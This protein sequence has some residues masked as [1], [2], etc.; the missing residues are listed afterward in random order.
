MSSVMA[1]LLFMTTFNLNNRDKHK[2]LALARQSIE[3]GL[4]SGKP[5]SINVKDYQPPLTDNAACFVTLTINTLNHNRQLRGCIGSLEARRPLVRDIC[6]NAFASAFCDSRFAPLSA[7]E[8]EFIHIEISVLTPL[9]EI[10]FRSQDELLQQ[11]E[12]FKDGLLLEEGHHRG[13]FLPLVWQQLPDK[14]AFISHLKQKAGLPAN[15]WS[16]TLRCYR[17]QSLV[18]EEQ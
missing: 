4:R 9:Q 12:P 5:L 17:Y 8:L 15:Y 10:K 11:I 16:D 18:F 6:E 7:S 1:P 3:Q 2:L 14:H 13:T